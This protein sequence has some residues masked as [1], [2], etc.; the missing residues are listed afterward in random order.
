MPEK[1]ERTRE[2]LGLVFD[3][4]YWDKFQPRDGDIVVTTSAKAGTT[5]CQTICRM[6]I[7]QSPTAPAPLDDLSP[8]F[9]LRLTPPEMTIPLLEAQ[10]H[11][12]FIK[13]HLPMDGIRYFDELRYIVVGRDSRDV[14]MSW[15]KHMEI[16]TPHTTEMFNAHSGEDLLQ[17]ADRYEIDLP[18]EQRAIFAGIRAW[19]GP[20]F[21][22]PSELEDRRGIWKKWISEGAYPWEADG[23]PAVSHHSHLNT[24]WKH[25]ELENILFVHFNDLLADLDGEMRRIAAFLSIPVNEEIWPELVDAATFKSMKDK[26]QVTA[27]GTS[28]GAWRDPRDFFHKGT[29]K[30]WNDLL[31]D[32]DLALYEANV[33]RTLAPNARRWLEQGRFAV[34]DPGNL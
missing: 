9:D 7:F 28:F 23:W 8:W 20:E 30:R 33:E 14:F 27:P 11:R 12:R 6:L 24:W 15:L 17:V 16:M 5:W 29:N 21:P 10:T 1:P 3:S 26:A 13:S 25:R 22:S 31:S 2:Y 4:S 34:G 19:E 32:D 18:P